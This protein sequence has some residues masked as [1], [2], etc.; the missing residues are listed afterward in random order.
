MEADDDSVLRLGFTGRMT[1][2]M[3]SALILLLAFNGY[4]AALVLLRAQVYKVPVYRPML[5]NIALSMLQLVILG[6][7]VAGVF[8]IAEVPF[9]ASQAL[10]FTYVAVV[11]V[12]WTL[13]FPNSAYLITELNFNHRSNDQPVPLWYDIIATLT[14]TASGIANTVAGLAGIQIVA[15]LIFD[16]PNRVERYP[17]AWSWVFAVV[18]IALGAFGIYLGRYLRFNS[19]DVK[20]PVGMLRKLRSHFVDGRNRR[21]AALFIALHTGFLGLAYALIFLPVYAAISG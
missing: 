5:L 11:G 6:L 7:L 13:A 16:D 10:L 4:A 12:V 18:L 2:V 9:F 14:L 3:V 1:S 8:L 19:W 20:H 15:I 17:P 21:Q